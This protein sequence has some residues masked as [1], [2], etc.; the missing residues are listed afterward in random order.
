MSRDNLVKESG[1]ALITTIVVEVLL[2]GLGM[3][4]SHMSLRPLSGGGSA[5]ATRG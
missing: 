1:M 3:T 4:F 2:V 5:P